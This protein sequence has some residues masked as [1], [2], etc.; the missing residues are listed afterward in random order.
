MIHLP[1]GD[2]DFDIVAGRMSIDLIK[3][4]AI[5]LK[6]GRSSW[7]AAETVIDADHANNIEILA[8]IPAQA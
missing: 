6:K 3:E 1:D 5:T 2:I 4:N 7:Y 8:N